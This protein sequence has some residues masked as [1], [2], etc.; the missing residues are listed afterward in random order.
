MPSVKH[1]GG[2]LLLVHEPPVGDNQGLLRE[3]INE[4]QALQRQ[5]SAEGQAA[6]LG[7]GALGYA[8]SIIDI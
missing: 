5:V 4:P 2:L 8:L 3:G 1:P 6:S 7:S